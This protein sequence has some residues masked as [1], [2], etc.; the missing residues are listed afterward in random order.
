MELEKSI[1][2][3]VQKRPVGRPKREI[4]AIFVPIE[5]EKC[6]KHKGPIKTPPLIK[7]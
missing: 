7:C 3:E 6:D 1:K 2:K 5:K 4:G